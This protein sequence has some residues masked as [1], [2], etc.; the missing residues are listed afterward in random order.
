MV[1]FL[2]LLLIVTA[3][4]LILLVW[5]RPRADVKAPQSERP[6]RTVPALSAS[7]GFRLLSPESLDD[8]PPLQGRAREVLDAASLHIAGLRSVASRLAD[9]EVAAKVQELCA[10]SESIAAKIRRNPDSLPLVQRHYDY[11]LPTAADL[12]DRYDRL[13]HSKVYTKDME[14]QVKRIENLL[15]ALRSHFDKYMGKLL[16]HELIDLEVE[17]N[18]LEEVMR[19]ERVSG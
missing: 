12:M 14:F 5:L 18:T 2:L 19:S 15:P 11:Y 16:R 6:E 9:R 17:V 13:V 8:A 1:V 4:I 7:S 3:S 10:V